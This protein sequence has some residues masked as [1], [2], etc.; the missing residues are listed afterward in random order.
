MA[1][2]PSAKKDARKSAVRAQRNRSIRSAVKTKVTKFRRA[3][4]EQASGLQ[5]LAVV[6]VSALDRAVTKGV[7]HRNNAARR[8]SRL[9]KRLNGA[10]QAQQQAPVAPAAPP[11]VAPKTTRT[12]SRTS[13]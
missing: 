5:G 8:K 13:R 12:R 3:A 11:R 4:S 1:N 7:L 10:A 9:M 6:A 2:T